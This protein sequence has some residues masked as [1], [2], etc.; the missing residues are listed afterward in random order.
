MI[1]LEKIY[2]KSPVWIQNLM[3]S[4][5]GYMICRRRYNK[6]FHRELSRYQNGYYKQSR[7]LA[8]MLLSI[9]DLHVGGVE[10][11]LQ[12]VDWDAL[13]KDDTIAYDI[14]SKFPIINKAIVK[15]N[16]K[17]Y[18]N[19]SYVGPTMEARTSGTTGGA[20][21]FPYPVD[22]ENKQWAVWWRYR[23]NLGLSLDT[24][25]GWFGGKSV[26][27]RNTNKPPYWRLN[28][29][30]K[31]VMFSS[32]H[33]TADTAKW[34]HRAIKDKKLTWLHGYPSHIARFAGLVIDVG[35]DLLTDVLF[36]TTGAENLFEHQIALISRAFPN[37]VIRQHYGLGEGVANISQTIDGEWRVDDDFCYVEFIPTKEDKQKYHIVG[38]AFSNLAFPLIRYDTGDLATIV[39]GKIISIDGRTSNVINQPS[40]HSICEAS[41]S[42]VLH[43]FANIIEAQFHQTS[44]D[45]VTLF[46]VRSNAYTAKDERLL[47]EA[48]NKTFEKELEVDIQYVNKAERTKA[49][50]LRLVISDIT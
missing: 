20:L 17:D 46:V 14:I 44:I 25:C 31:Q 24:W 37:A 32:Y 43:D 42:I 19:D 35:L 48:L 3:C 6:A 5:K 15:G 21:I 12:N 41:L 45:K 8:V 34:Y 28:V 16:I 26:L 39:D 18:I 29:P 11:Y 1:L 27:P 7:Q 9:R 50:K 10:P 47:R 33:L 36:V 30:G 22:M 2:A 23:I 13:S 49:G 40:G 38:T 4:A